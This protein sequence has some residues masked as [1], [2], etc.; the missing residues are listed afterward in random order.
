MNDFSILPPTPT[1]WSRHQ[2]K[3]GRVRCLPR[4]RPVFLSAHISPSPVPPWLI[5]PPQTLSSVSTGSSSKENKQAIQVQVPSTAGSRKK[6][7]RTKGRKQNL[8]STMKSL[9]QKVYLD[10]LSHFPVFTLGL[11][12]KAE[13]WYFSV[14][15]LVWFFGVLLLLLTLIF[16][17]CVWG[18]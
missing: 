10:F 4:A 14:F 8:S 15:S 9:S 3:I 5:K 6:G 18:G 13:K 12:Q 1:R 11:S 2:F 17:L 7:E 16:I